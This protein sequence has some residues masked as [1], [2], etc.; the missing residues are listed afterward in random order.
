MRHFNKI[1][2]ASVLILFLG[3]ALC[4]C[5]KEETIVPPVYG[6]LGFQTDPDAD[7]IGMYV[8]NE[9]NMGSNKADIDFLDYREAS[10]AC[11]IYAEKN[12]TVVKGLGDTGNDL[13]IYDGR[14]F[15]VINGSHKVEVMDAYTAERIT[16]IDI[17][18]CRYIA[19][20]DN[21]AYVTAYVGSD[22]EF[23]ADR[24]GS[25]FKVNLDTYKIE[26]ET[27]VGYQ[28]EEI[29]IIGS[30]AFVA[31]SGGY[32]AP[33][34]DSTV[35]VIDVNSMKELYTIDVAINLC[36]IKADSKGNLWVSSNGN[37]VD[38]ASNLYR[39]ENDGTQYKV[40]EAMN[41]PVSNM[42][43]ANDSLYIYSS[44]YS[45]VTSSSTISYAIVDADRKSVVSR[46]VITDGTESQIVA[47]YG[48]AVH[49]T[50]GDIYITD[51]KNYTS[52][53]TLYCYSRS[54]VQKWSATTG[55]IPGH[56]AFLPR[57][58]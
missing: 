40:A 33:D 29:V 6:P 5:R 27:P 54:G 3:A 55:D 20:K 57:K 34:Y 13:Q 58:K 39:L 36:H 25:V 22:A 30:N 11:G 16:Q 42:T 31:N 1:I 46:K 26:G 44:E 7:P 51:A 4:G 12:P 19:F 10:Y 28:P 23:Q 43:I 52:S 18:N 37:Y 38:V 21:Y 50:N 9:G 8:L 32:R 45:Y 17:A 49:P 56:F 41:I 35:S 53:G 48:I 14:L 2:K 24:K 47:P 15:A